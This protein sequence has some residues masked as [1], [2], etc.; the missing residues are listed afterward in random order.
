MTSDLEPIWLI[1]ANVVA[2][3]PWG[4]DGREMRPGTKSFAGGS[5]VYVVR[6]YWGPGGERLEVIG[7]ARHRS[8][9]I[10]IN[11]ATRHLYDFRPKLVH[12]PRVLERLSETSYGRGFCADDARTVSATLERCARQYRAEAAPSQP[13]PE[14]CLCH[15][16]LTGESTPVAGS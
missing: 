10:I 8:R 11:T 3:R 1:A 14:H 5:K 4:P 13:H 15:A 6:V 12:T 7:R 16:C 2:F 9:W